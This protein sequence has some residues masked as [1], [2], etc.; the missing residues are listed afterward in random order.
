MKNIKLRSNIINI[1]FE[2]EDGNVKLT[3]HFDKSDENAKRLYAAFDQLED[4]GPDSDI[5]SDGIEEAKS[6]LKKSMDAIFGD[7]SFDKLYALNPSTVT[8]GIYFYQIA[9]GIKEEME[10]D[11]IKMIE[12]KYLN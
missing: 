6:S 5:D 4:F 8:V 2:D 9:I 10:L 12:D 11:D 3:L 1:P 7:G